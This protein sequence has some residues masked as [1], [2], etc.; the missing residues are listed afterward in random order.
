[1]CNRL[2]LL[3]LATL[4]VAVP[5]V[6]AAAGK[7]GPQPEIAFLVCHGET[8]AGPYS[9]AEIDGGAYS[10]W[11]VDETGQRVGR[12]DHGP[13]YV[14]TIEVTYSHY[15][16]AD[17]DGVLHRSEVD[18]R[19]KL[20]YRQAMPAGLPMRMAIDGRQGIVAAEI[21]ASEI[22]YAHGWFAGTAQ[23]IN[24]NNVVIDDADPTVVHIIYVNFA[25][26][27][28]VRS[29]AIMSP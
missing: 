13:V 7:S 24:R 14:E 9:D 16:D 1:M 15:D 5:P 8:F 3:V 6:H 19:L 4:V 12:M 17:G 10:V 27:A 25:V 18:G 20:S 21:E 11:C 29:P 22:D 23:I 28:F 2:S 26:Y